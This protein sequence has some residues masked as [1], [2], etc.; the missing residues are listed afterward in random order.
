MRR[1]LIDLGQQHRRAKDSLGGGCGEEGG[2]KGSAGPAARS[3]STSKGCHIVKR[4][5]MCV[6]S[7][8]AA[9]QMSTAIPACQGEQMASASKT[10][11]KTS[12]FALPSPKPMTSQDD[13]ANQKSFQRSN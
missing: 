10:I 6:G 7:I 2:L 11:L 5:Y 1:V 8:E 12:E 4:V 3:S 13:H 9:V